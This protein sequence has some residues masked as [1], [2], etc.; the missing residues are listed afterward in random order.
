MYATRGG[1][2]ESHTNKLQTPGPYYDQ[3]KSQPGKARG[4]GARP[5]AA[6]KGD[7]RKQ[8]AIPYHMNPN[9]PYV[10]NTKP[11]ANDLLRELLTAPGGLDKMN[12]QQQYGKL[13]EMRQRQAMIDRSDGAMREFQRLTQDMTDQ[14][15]GTVRQLQE[16]P[17]A[18]ILRPPGGGGVPE[19]VLRAVANAT[20]RQKRELEEAAAQVQSRAVGRGPGGT[21]MVG[22]AANVGARLI[23]SDAVAPVADTAAA[24]RAGFQHGI[25]TGVR[26]EQQRQGKGRGRGRG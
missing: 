16:N 24:R 7:F 21:P 13:V 3:L 11:V 5:M 15:R 6:M 2:P 1:G 14:E 4:K 17:R 18:P 23:T 9:V 8:Q 26:Q 19:R 12:Q 25:A 20:E 10:K 22:G